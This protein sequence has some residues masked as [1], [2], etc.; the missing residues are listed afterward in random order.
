[1]SNAHMRRNRRLRQDDAAQEAAIIH[2]TKLGYHVERFDLHH[3]RVEYYIDW[4]PI[5]G[6]WRQMN[7][8]FAGMGLDDLVSRLKQDATDGTN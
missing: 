4:W 6:R 5:T 8:A 1:M 7:G 3:Y 2:L